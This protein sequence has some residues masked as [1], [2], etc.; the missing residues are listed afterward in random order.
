MKTTP[1]R[2]K[3]I[4]KPTIE[5]LNIDEYIDYLDQRLEKGYLISDLEFPTKHYQELSH[6]VKSHCI[7]EG[8]KCNWIPISR[9]NRYLESER[10]VDFLGEDKVRMRLEF[11]VD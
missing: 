11:Y 3:T 6:K 1:S 2:L 10:V 7:I 4:V 8:F 9:S 5:E